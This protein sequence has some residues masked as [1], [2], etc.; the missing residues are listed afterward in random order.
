MSPQIIVLDEAE[1]ELAEAESWYEE[2]RPGLGSEFLHA[3]NEAVLRL[4]EEPIASS[5]VP[6][7][8]ETTGARILAAAARL[9]EFGSWN[10]DR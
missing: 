2:Q 4:L 1:E 5:P 3:V 8:T 7:L 6:G 9:E 10:E